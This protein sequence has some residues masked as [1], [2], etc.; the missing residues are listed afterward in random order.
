MSAKVASMVEEILSGLEH[1]DKTEELEALIPR[2]GW[3]VL[4]DY[5]MTILEDPARSVEDWAIT[6]AVFWGA[7]LDKVSLNGDRLI[8]LLYVRLPPDEGSSESNLA[9]SVASVL[10][11]RSY[12]S[13]YDPLEDP[14]V[15][16]ERE[17]IRV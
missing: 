13:S 1:R 5:L 7:V 11:G 4:R 17:T 14:A 2:V 12:L 8:A 3:E 10:K 6:A 15:K 9:W 16:R